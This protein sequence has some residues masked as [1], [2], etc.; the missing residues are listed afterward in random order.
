MLHPFRTPCELGGWVGATH[1]VGAPAFFSTKCL[2]SIYKMC[3]LEMSL[4]KCLA[5]DTLLHYKMNAEKGL[6]Q[7]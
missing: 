5:L 2:A 7:G 1:L 4:Q 3:C 6:K